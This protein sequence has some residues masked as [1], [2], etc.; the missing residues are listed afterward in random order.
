MS[1][2]ESSAGMAEPADSL[3]RAV[4]RRRFDRRRCPR[5]RRI[6]VANARP[7][8][9]DRE[10]VRREWRRRHRGRREERGGWLHHSD[11]HRPGR[12]VAAYLQ[13]ELRSDERPG[14]GDPTIAPA[15][16]ARSPSQARRPFAHRIRH[17]RQAA[18][19]ARLR[20]VRIGFT[21]TYRRGVVCEARRHHAG[22]R[23]VSRRRASHQRPCRR[24]HHGGVAR[25]VAADS[26]LQGGHAAAAGADDGRALCQSAGRADVPGSRIRGARARPMARRVRAHWDPA[27]H[28]RAPQCRG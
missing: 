6:P 27:D 23:A 26:A 24:P 17:R 28:R 1:E 22:P 20:N 15:G 4:S 9:R 21:A 8:D 10:Q 5:H 18:T 16:R 2:R 13:V 14:A 19:K 25:I 3:H 12:H 7:A 11:R